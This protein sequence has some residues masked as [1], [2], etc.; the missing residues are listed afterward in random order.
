ML[1]VLGVTALLI[2]CIQY[3]YE[4]KELDRG[5]TPFR[6]PL[7]VAGFVGLVGT[8]ALMNVLFSIGPF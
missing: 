6:L 5:R 1:I 3:W 8:M 4:I 2:A 7:A